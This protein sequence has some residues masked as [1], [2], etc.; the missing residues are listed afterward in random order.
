MDYRRKKLF[1]NSVLN[2]RKMTHFRLCMLETQ[3]SGIQSAIGSGPITEADGY[4]TVYNPSSPQPWKLSQI[5][6][7]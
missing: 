7:F 4:L 6:T 1:V 3:V 5:F 2:L